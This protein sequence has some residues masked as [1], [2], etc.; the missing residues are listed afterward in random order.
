MKT[1]DLLRDQCQIQEYVWNRLDN[2]EPDWDWALGDADRKVSLIATGF[3]FEQNGWFSMVLDRRPRAQS[4][5]QWQSLIG[6]NYLPMPHW[7]LDDDYELVV[8]HY[9]PKWKPPKNGFD[10]E[11][12]A[13][14]FGNTIRDALVHI[15][16]QNGFAFN[17]LARNCAFFVE[18]H[19]GRFGWPEYK[20]TR[21]AGR[22]RP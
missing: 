2:Y 22:C 17:F 7:N 14:L 1:L 9:D 18:E 3:S 8:K 13:E 21:T 10:D 5:G 12:A 20:E 6:H 11:S 19:E 4:D 16:D 15:R